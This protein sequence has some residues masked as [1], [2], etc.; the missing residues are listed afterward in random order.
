MA[1]RSRSSASR[2]RG[3]TGKL[4]A[5]IL[6]ALVTLAAAGWGV[7]LWVTAPAPTQRDK[8]TLCPATQPKDII[9]IVL[10]TTDGLPDPARIEATTRLTDLID[11]S[12]QGALLDMRV[13]D[14]AHPAGRLVLTLCN[15]GDGRNLSEWT[16]NPDMAKRLWR[17][18]FREP[19]V[20][21][22]EG[23]LQTTPAKSSPL[24][25]TF[26]GI[27]LGRF[28]GAQVASAHKRLVIVSDLIEH[29]PGEY[30]Q[31]PPADLH[32]ARF[33]SSP[34]Y[35]KLHTDLQGADVTIFYID[36]NGPGCRPI[37]TGAHMIFWTSWIE[38]NNGRVD[39]ETTRKLQGACK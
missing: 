9:V 23:S 31:Y 33:K 26:Q 29:V 27:A 37:D 3:D 25:A 22:L 13:I 8:V 2:P 5:A 10:D 11:A 4:I 38:D 34:V 12:P 30:S 19:L 18:R 36:R 32:Y 35:R 1:R 6:L 39:V 14:P 24:L 20:R 15:P 28:T 16:G 21:A 17:E 7:H